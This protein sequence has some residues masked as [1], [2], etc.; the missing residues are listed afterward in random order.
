MNKLGDLM[1]AGFKKQSYETVSG[2]NN[3]VEL[4]S[5]LLE[6]TVANNLDALTGLDAKGLDDGALVFIRN[7]GASNVLTIKNNDI[8]SDDKNRIRISVGDITLPP[9]RWAFAVQNS[10]GWDAFIPVSSLPSGIQVSGFFT[11]APTGWVL[12]NGGTIGSSTSGATLLAD[13][14]AILLYVHLWDNLADAQAPVSS[15]RGASALADFAANK[16][17]VVPDHRGFFPFGK[18]AAGTGST[19]GGTFG[20]KD[21]THDVVVDGEDATLALG[22]VQVGADDT[23][24]TSENNPPGLAKTFIIK[25]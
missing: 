24:T 8:N 23:Y 12:M 6:I 11:T 16:T 13:A 14:S 5:S 1:F 15:G 18:D 2:N 10:P 21:H 19:M 20:A 7:V 3:N 4:Q 9:G 25:L 22:L 17:I